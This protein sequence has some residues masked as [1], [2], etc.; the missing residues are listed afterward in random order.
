MVT[1]MNVW[2]KLGYVCKSGTKLAEKP[3]FYYNI[4]LITRTINL[5][6]EYSCQ[7]ELSNQRNELQKKNTD[8]SSECLQRTVAESSK[9]ASLRVV[10]A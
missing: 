1:P 8:S 5:N 4:V 3:S 7:N 9:L 2:I 6:E 10:L